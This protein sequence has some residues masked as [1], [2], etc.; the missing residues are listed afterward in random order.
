MIPPAN[1]G[2]LLVL[3]ELSK[4]YSMHVGYILNPKSTYLDKVYVRQVFVFYMKATYANNV[5]YSYLANI[6]GFKG[7]CA[8]TKAINRLAEKVLDEKKVPKQFGNLI[9]GEDYSK[10][11][12]KLD[13]CLLE[14]RDI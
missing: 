13:K 1:K 4:I 11:K 6:L 8:V 2:Y 3:Q 14:Y 10:T 7:A 9:V 12:I 5:S